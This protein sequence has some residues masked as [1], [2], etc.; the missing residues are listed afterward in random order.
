M[1]GPASYSPLVAQHFAEPE[2]VGELKQCHAASSRGRA[3]GR[4][5]GTEVVFEV[6]IDEDRVTELTFRAFGCPHTIAACSVL[7]R[8]FL[9]EPVAALGAFRP[10]ELAA[11]LDLPPDKMGRLLVVQDALREA[12]VNWENNRLA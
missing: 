2:G 1:S 8:R 7:T 12:L 9:G 3:G 11:E 4:E 10:A 6:G 5:H